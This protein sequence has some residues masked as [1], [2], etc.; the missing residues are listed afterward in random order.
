[1]TH[2]PLR[3]G[4][5][6]KL[7]WMQDLGYNTLHLHVTESKTSIPQISCSS[8]SSPINGKGPHLNRQFPSGIDLNKIVPDLL[9]LT[10]QAEKPNIQF[11]QHIPYGLTVNHT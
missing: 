3:N 9:K 4:F 8:E 7:I 10:T 11:S 5:L 6:H 1:M 2:H